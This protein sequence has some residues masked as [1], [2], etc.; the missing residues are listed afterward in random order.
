MATVVGQSALYKYYAESVSRSASCYKNIYAN[1]QL[2]D[3]YSAGTLNYSYWKYYREPLAGG[4]RELI[5]TTYEPCHTFINILIELDNLQSFK[6]VIELETE[7]AMLKLQV[8]QL[9]KN[10]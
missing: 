9:M 5:M 2:F 1:G 8:E 4:S 10:E 3:T 6:R 7:V